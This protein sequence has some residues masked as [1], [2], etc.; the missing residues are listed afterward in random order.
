MMLSKP[1][2]QESNAVSLGLGHNLLGIGM[3]CSPIEKGEVKW[4]NIKLTEEEAWIKLCS[5]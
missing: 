1:C 2:L 4:C 5:R 3:S